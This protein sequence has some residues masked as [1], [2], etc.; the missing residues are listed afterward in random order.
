MLTEVLLFC[1]G[2]FIKRPRLS[3]LQSMATQTLWRPFFKQAR[4]RSLYTRW[5]I[6]HKALSWCWIGFCTR[7]FGQNPMLILMVNMTVRTEASFL[8]SAFYRGTNC[9]KQ[10]NKLFKTYVVKW[11]WFV[12]LCVFASYSYYNCVRFSLLYLLVARWKL[13]DSVRKKRQRALCGYS[14]SSGR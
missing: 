12:L 2:R 10:P 1:L 4:S 3:G 13:A 8:W 6:V 14:S 9:T 11:I 7:R 5:L